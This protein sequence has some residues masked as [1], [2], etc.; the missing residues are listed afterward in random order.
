MKRPEADRL[1]FRGANIGQI[2]RNI[3]ICETSSG[4]FPASQ[5]KI[6]PV[7]LDGW[8]KGIIC[9]YTQRLG[10]LNALRKIHKDSRPLKHFYRPIARTNSKARTVKVKNNVLA[11]YPCDRIICKSWHAFGKRPVHALRNEA[12]TI[13]IAEKLNIF[14]VPQVVL[15]QSGSGSGNV[16]AIW[17]EKIKGKK[18][19]TD[20]ERKKSA[21]KFM[22]AMFYW[23]EEH[24]IDFKKPLEIFKKKSSLEDLSSEGWSE[25]EADILTKALIRI[26]KID[27]A[28]PLSWIHGD[29]TVGNCIINTR[30]QIVIFDWEMTK[31]DLIVRDTSKL[32]RQGGPEAQILYSAWLKRVSTRHTEILEH[33]FQEHIL[34]IA[35][36]LNIIT[37]IL[38]SSD[39][40]PDIQAKDKTEAIKEHV[41]QSAKCISGMHT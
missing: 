27:K 6:R 34:K 4:L 21:V 19:E 36:N 2:L 18:P 1:P 16:P 35:N 23:Y 10:H 37:E 32:I 24:G 26:S 41:L 31:R 28:M 40:P 11:F 13:A 8:T 25:H 7:F 22:K 14:R 30:N 9:S 5:D 3:E 38:H 33:D 12:D 39:D 17:Y 20:N 29:A 15:D